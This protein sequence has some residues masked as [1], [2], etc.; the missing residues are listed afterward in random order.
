MPQTPKN[1]QRGRERKSVVSLIPGIRD[2][3]EKGRVQ[4]GQDAYANR[5]AVRLWLGGGG[6]G[7]PS[8]G[9]R[10]GA[11][12]HLTWS[13]FISRQR[14]VIHATHASRVCVY[15][16]SLV[17]RCPRETCFTPDFAAMMHANAL[18]IDPTRS[19]LHKVVVRPRYWRKPDLSPRVYTFECSLYFFLSLLQVF[20]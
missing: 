11:R 5:V 2:V 7:W 19:I 16:A 10:R 3:V 15:T 9:G 6:G 1:L 4:R 17:G 8:E 18:Q 13:S 20:R 12:G 14:S